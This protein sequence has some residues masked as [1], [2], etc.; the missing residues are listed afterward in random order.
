M[1]KGESDFG[2]QT[3]DANGKK[4]KIRMENPILPDGSEQELYLPNGRF[5][6]MVA[7]LQERGYN[8]SGLKAECQ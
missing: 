7:L 2:A 4:I 8:T 5:K 6:G 1:T 3:V